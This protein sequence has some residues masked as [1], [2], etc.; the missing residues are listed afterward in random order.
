MDSLP[1]SV[2]PTPR[3]NQSH[4]KFEEQDYDNQRTATRSSARP[5]HVPEL[6]IDTILNN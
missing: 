5:S 2:T 3:D 6:N 4:I 1:P